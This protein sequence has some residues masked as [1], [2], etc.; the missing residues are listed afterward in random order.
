MTP[1][2]YSRLYDE[3]RD[4]APFSNG[5]EG[6]GW[7]SANCST[8]IHDKPAR[9]GDDANG[10]PLILVA[11]MGR[12]P[13]QWMEGPRSPEGYISIANQYRC[14]EYRH[15]DDGPTDPQPI[16]DPPGQLTLVPREI[17]EGVRML[18]PLPEPV[19]VDEQVRASAVLAHVLL[20]AQVAELEAAV[21]EARR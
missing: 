4:E 13:I 5:T 12:T 9:N 2:D 20:A 21:K 7:L 15:E 16:P 18:T 10:C 6:D 19:P 14:I 3:A 1:D 11:L 17:Y 8:C